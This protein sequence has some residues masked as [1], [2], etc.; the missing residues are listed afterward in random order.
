M[1]TA[2]TF[3]SKDHYFGRNLDLEYHYSEA[4]T[5]MPRNY[6]LPIRMEEK[7]CSRYAI[8]GMATVDNRYPLYYDATNEYGLSIAALNFP[9]NAVYNKPLPGMQNIT[10]YELIPWLLGKCKTLAD[11]KSVLKTVNLIDLPYSEEYPLTPLHWL[12]A[13]QTGSVTLE[14]TKS[15][16][17]IIDNPVGVLTNNPPFAYHMINLQNYM[18]LSPN[19]PENKIYPDIPLSHYSNGMG[20]LG[21]PGDLSSTSRFIRAVFTKSNCIPELTE[22]ASINQFFHILDSVYQP[23]GCV[24]VGNAYERT[25]Y[26]CCCNMD[27]GVYY[28]TTYENRQITAISLNKAELNCEKLIIYPLKKQQQIRYEN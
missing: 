22:D 17:E 19:Q 16:L 28:Y 2:I 27:T 14:P 21:L 15:G 24:K 3:H 23:Y 1:C 8:I 10:P 13:D 5:I 26:S 7:F 11:A 12:L 18:H 4:V 6:H 20:A 9:G 25:Q